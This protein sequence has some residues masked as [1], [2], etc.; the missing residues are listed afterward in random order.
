MI[1][2]SRRGNRRRTQCVRYIANESQDW[3]TAWRWEDDV[4][5]T[6]AQLNDF[7]ESGSIVRELNRNDIRQVLVGDYRVIYRVKRPDNALNVGASWR[8][9]EDIGPYPKER[10]ESFDPTRSFSHPA[11][12]T[13]HQ[14]PSTRHQAPSTRH[15]TPTQ[16]SQ[17][18]RT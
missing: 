4:F 17:P 8:A 1:K 7:P 18:A 11:L 14:A 9:D 5:A 2:W 15:Q 3:F 6:T 10:A 12:G 16:Y 13:R